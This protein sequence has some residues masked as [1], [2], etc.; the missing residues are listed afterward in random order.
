MRREDKYQHE[1]FNCSVEVAANE[2]IHPSD[3][4]R[5]HASLSVTPPLTSVLKGY[6]ELTKPGIT[7][8]VVLTAAVGYYVGLPHS[9]PFASV[10]N[11]LRFVVF[12]CATTLVSAGACALNHYV[13]RNDD[14]VMKRTAQRPIPSGLISANAALIFAVISSVVGLSAMFL[15]NTLTFALALCTTLSYVF[16]YTPMKKK[17]WIAMLVG[18]IPGALP[19][20]GG[21]TASTGHTDMTAFLLFAIM[22]VWQ[23][24]HFLALA[25]M[26][27]HD[28]ERGG[29]ALLRSEESQQTTVALH[30]L[31]Y[32]AILLPLGIMLGVIANVGSLFV[33]G[34]VILCAVFVYTALK[35]VRETTPVRARKLLLT[36]YAYVM[37]VF[38][39]MVIDKV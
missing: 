33:A 38:L 22:F 30:A 35:V 19:V 4:E 28:Y 39:L 10:D 9:I 13:E 14:A 32:T 20:L 18:G 11:I 24:P 27:R 23:M 2:H 21:Y 6:Y 5:V 36:S 29:F 7:Q 12:A 16:V 31:I 37:G 17:S 25:M 34:H 26:Y 8:M 15:I 1:D 3:P